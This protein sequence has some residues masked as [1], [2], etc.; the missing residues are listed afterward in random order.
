MHAEIKSNRLRE[1]PIETE[2]NGVI[3]GEKITRE[4]LM[5]V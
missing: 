2:E 3:G 5:N 1:T 4:E